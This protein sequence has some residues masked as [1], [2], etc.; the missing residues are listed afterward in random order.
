M[1]ILTGEAMTVYSALGLLGRRWTGTPLQMKRGIACDKE[2]KLECGEVRWGGELDRTFQWVLIRG[3]FQR[4]PAASQG[5]LQ[6][7]SQKGIN[8]PSGLSGYC[9][10]PRADFRRAH[11]KKGLQMAGESSYP[12]DWTGKYIALIWQCRG[13]ML[14]DEHC[15]HTGY[16]MIMWLLLNQAMIWQGHF[17][18]SITKEKSVCKK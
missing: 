12:H 16:C 6:F 18:V 2:P 3:T 17:K 9:Q 4:V 8:M 1:S 7:S 10:Y 5:L 11:L 13:R 14:V 15:I